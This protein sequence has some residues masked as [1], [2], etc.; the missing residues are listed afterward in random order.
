MLP[1]YWAPVGAIL[2]SLGGLVYLVETLR[3]RARPNRITWLLWGLFPLVIYAAQRVQGVAGITWVSLASG[4]TP[5]LVFAAS[6]LN[7]RAYWQSGPRDYL[8][9]VAALVGLG[10]WAVTDSPNLALLCALVADGL[11]SL[12]TLA[13]AYRHPASES[14]VAYAISAS[15]FGLSLLSIPAHS[16]EHTAFVTYVFVLNGTLALLAARAHSVPPTAP[17]AS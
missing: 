11:A 13:K 1:A 15:G 5:L 12:P 9:M 16:L 10:L 3:G 14:W 4:L 17:G 2:G 6:F 8:L 7:P